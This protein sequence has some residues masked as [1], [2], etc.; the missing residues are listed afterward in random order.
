MS[1][2]PEVTEPAG[3]RDTAQHSLLGQHPLGALGGGIFT[4]NL[5]MAHGGPAGL[6]LRRAEVWM[7]RK[8][9]SAFSW[10]VRWEAVG[11][12]QPVAITPHHGENQPMHAACTQREAG[13]RRDTSGPTLR[14]PGSWLVGVARATHS[15]FL[16]FLPLGMW[17]DGSLRFISATAFSEELIYFTSWVD[18]T[19]NSQSK[20]PPRP[21]SPR[22]AAVS[23]STGMATKTFETVVILSVRVPACAP[24]DT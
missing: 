15:I 17:L 5:P 18:G 14:I 20:I 9:N 21:A 23:L 3:G 4:S 12:G 13:G 24:W 8:E 2:L 16:P 6:F 7:L 22:P 1:E 10:A 11:C 19:F